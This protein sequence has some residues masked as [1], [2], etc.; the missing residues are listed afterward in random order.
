M[1]KLFKFAIFA[2]LVTGVVK[3]VSAQKAEWQGLSESQV[4]SKLHDKLDDRMPADKVDEIGD[5]IVGKMRERGVLGED[6]PAEA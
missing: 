5:K 2:A 4:R 3:M 1:K 6:E